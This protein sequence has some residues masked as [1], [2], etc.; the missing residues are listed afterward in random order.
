LAKQHTKVFFVKGGSVMVTAGGAVARGRARL[1][2]D[3]AG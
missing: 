3:L 2:K 1:K